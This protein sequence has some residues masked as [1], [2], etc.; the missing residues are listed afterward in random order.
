M[1]EDNLRYVATYLPYDVYIKF[2]LLCVKKDI[3]VSKAL[4]SLVVAFVKDV[5][6]ED[7]KNEAKIDSKP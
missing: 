7:K 5:N 2:K 6:L 4:L 1:S 3:S